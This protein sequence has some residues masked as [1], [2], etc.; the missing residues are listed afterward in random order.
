MY[1]NIGKKIKGLAK[2]IFIVEA[3]SAVI[4]AIALMAEDDDF[5]W[6]GLLLI[7]VGPLVAWVS[8]W[9]LY[10]FGELVDKTCDI[11]R[12]TRGGFVQI[13]AAKAERKAK[14]DAMLAEG[15]ITVEEYQQA[16]SKNG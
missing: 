1:D 9:M 12:N 8:S 15:L 4:S 7:V 13:D 6:I 10:A 14:L 11:E 5:I 3:V 16:M 2:W